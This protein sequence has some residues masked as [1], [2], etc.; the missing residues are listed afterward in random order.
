MDC[1]SNKK[2]AVKRQ[3]STRVS[4]VRL[5]SLDFGIQLFGHQF[6]GGVILEASEQERSNHQTKI[7]YEKSLYQITYQ[8]FLR[9][10]LVLFCHFNIFSVLLNIVHKLEAIL[11]KYQCFTYIPL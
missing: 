8:V 10:W 5:N 4:N 3:I 11:A 7:K 2:E 9:R 1:T 6:K